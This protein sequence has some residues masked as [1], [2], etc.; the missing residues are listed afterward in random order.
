MPFCGKCGNQITGQS[1]FCP[2][3]GNEIEQTH[4]TVFCR[5][6]GSQVMGNSLFCPNC[7]N[8]VGLNANFV[9][10][11]NCGAHIDEKAIICPRCG[12]QQSPFNRAI[13]EKNVSKAWIILGFLFPL[14]GLIL[15]LVWHEERPKRAKYIGDGIIFYVLSIPILT[16]ICFYP[17]AY[18]QTWAF[19]LLAILELILDIELIIINIVAYIRGRNIASILIIATVC[20]MLFMGSLGIY[21]FIIATIVNITAGI[22]LIYNNYNKKDEY[23]TYHL[24]NGA[25]MIVAT[26]AYAIVGL[27]LNNEAIYILPGTIV[28]ITLWIVLL[29]TSVTLLKSSKKVKNI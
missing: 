20:L 25:L 12:V 28:S 6:C 7:G 27:T 2:N 17:V 10:C 26:I 23:R 5:K 18:F 1:R 9:Y 22:L 4:D 24:T 29:L 11:R 21:G 8:R 3:C 15:Y 13:E 14:L 16:F 19:L